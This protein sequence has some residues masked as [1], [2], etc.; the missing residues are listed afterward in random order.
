MLMSRRKLLCTTAEGFMC[1]AREAIAERLPQMNEARAASCDPL[2]S[3]L[4]NFV[5]ENKH[6]NVRQRVSRLYRPVNRTMACHVLDPEN[7]WKAGID[8]LKAILR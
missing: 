1:A 6:Q 7:A 2:V 3:Y 4:S 8:A 5:W